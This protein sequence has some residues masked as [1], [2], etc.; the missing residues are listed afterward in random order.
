MKY[1]DNSTRKIF[2]QIHLAQNKNRFSTDKIKFSLNEKTF[3]LKKGFFR[4]KI[5]ADLG[6]GST[7][8]GGFNL[9]NLGAKYCHLLDMHKHIKKPIQKNLRK[10]KNKFEVTIGSLEKLPYLKNYFDFVLCQ[11]VIHH[12]D[13]DY[14]GY[15][16]VFRVL[17]KGGLAY[18]SVH[19]RGGLINDLTMNFIRP[20]YQ[21]NKGFRKFIDVLL[22]KNYKKY[23][24][25][26]KKN[27]DKDTIRLFNMIKFLFDDDLKLTIKDRLMA[28]KYKTYSEK[29][30]KIYLEKVGFKK[31]K[32]IKK[33]VQFKNIRRFIQPLYHHYDSEI[34]RFLYGDGIIHL[35]LKK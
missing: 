29:K 4:G 34:S 2:N 9:L 31:I 32:R 24:N 19:G 16:E 23:V 15:K 13:N 21:K 26:L 25:F 33:K 8:S 27:Y 28:P 10:F 30:L 5:C 11:G 22:N 6:C 20:K 18:I 1:H 7:G 35:L 14:K 17:K 12:M 3:N